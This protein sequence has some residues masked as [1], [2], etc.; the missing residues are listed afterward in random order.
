[1]RKLKLLL[2]LCL[3][4]I[5]ASAED[6]Y[7]VTGSVADIFGTA[8]SPDGTANDMV[9]GNDGIYT[10]TYENVTIA[11]GTKIEYK[12]VA[13]HSWDN[14]SWGFGNNNAQYDVNKSG[15]YDITFS[16]N[17]NGEFSDG[18]KVYCALT[19]SNAFTGEGKVFIKNVATNLWWGAANDWGTHASLIPHADY[20][21]LHK[22][23]EGRYQ[24]E[25]QVNNGGTNNWFG[26]EWMDGSACNLNILKSGENYTIS[27]EDGNF[28]GSG[29]E[30]LTNGTQQLNLNVAG[31]SEAAI[32]QIL[33]ENDMRATLQTATNAA[34]QDATWLIADHNFAR[35]HRGQRGKDK[36]GVWKVSDDCTNYSLQG[37]N[38]NKHCAESFHSVFTHIQQTLTNIPNGWYALTAQ[39]FYRQD[40]TDNENLPHFFFGDKK[41]NVPLKTGS[42]DS[43]A[44]ACTSFESGLY[45]ID[46]IFVEVTNGTITVGIKNPNNADLWIIWDNFELTYYGTEAPLSVLKDQLQA[47]I[48]AGRTTVSG[49]AVPTGVKNTFETTASYYETAKSSYTAAI[50]VTDAIDAIVAAVEAAKAAEA[51]TAENAKVLAKAT[52]AK[53]ELA[54][55]ADTE[56]ATLQ[57]VINDNEAAL[58]ACATAAAVED[59]N[60]VLWTAIGT[61]I[62]SINV[63]TQLDLTFLLTNPNVDAFYTGDHG[64]KVEGWYTEQSDGNFQVVPGEGCANADGIHKHAYEY[65]SEAPKSNNKFT[66]YQKVNLPEG[67]YTINCYA[68]AD[69]S[70][71][72]DNRGI[73]FYANDTQGSLVANNTLTQQE[74]SF[75]NDAQQEVKIGLKAVTGNTYRWMGIGYMELYK[76]AAKSYTVDESV[77]W[78]NTTEGAGNVTLKRTIKAGMN[79]VVFPFSMTQTEVEEKFG[80]DS[81]VYALNSFAND[82][83]SFTTKTDGISA[84]QPVLLDAKTAGTSYELEG[85]TIVAGEPKASV[86]GLDFIGTYADIFT[87]PQDSYV[88]SGGKFYLVD[89]NVTLKNTRAYF[90]ATSSTARILTFTLDGEEMTTGIATLENGELKVETGVI[91]DLSGR[92]VNNPTKGLYIIN[93]KKIVK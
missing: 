72:G 26:G 68:F 50:D 4:A 42:E 67:T 41:A 82:N 5:A 65:W 70:I 39:G 29:N 60:T 85:R 57:T 34:P 12:V 33:T 48:D 62:N 15:T 74:V 61:A 76:V 13:N 53:T 32:W 40:G 93:G 49:L 75:V 46:P 6:T 44:D 86:T 35:N 71:G 8:W 17:L 16:F 47:A 20:V 92:K 3:V 52:A 64:S 25:T 9:L 38:S 77:A 7:T 31:D 91:Y 2:V 1:M 37:G 90:A 59:Q 69:Q 56:K 51:P 88:L 79:T 19:L 11:E 23:P 81:K 73:Y 21:T 14:E 45:K 10:K 89:S 27:H 18:H 80:A 54:G 78:D 43:M 87:V 55:L 84:N 36:D 63:T 28:F 24:M 83:I 58:A 22:A 66:L 30:T